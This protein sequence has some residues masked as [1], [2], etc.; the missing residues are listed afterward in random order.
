[1]SL[2]A[3]IFD[4]DGAPAD[5]EEVKLAATTTSRPT[6]AWVAAIA[7]GETG[8]PKRPALDVTPTIWTADDDLSAADLDFDGF[9]LHAMAEIYSRSSNVRGREAA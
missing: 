6:L 3:L 7:P 8:V 2:R 1:M 4:V 9:I 5:T